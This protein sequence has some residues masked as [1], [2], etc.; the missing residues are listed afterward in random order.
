ML[1]RFEP[2][3]TSGIANSFLTKAVAEHGPLDQFLRHEDEN[4]DNFMHLVECRFAP[5]F[6]KPF[7]KDQDLERLKNVARDLL[8][9]KNNN[10]KTPVIKLL[11][12]P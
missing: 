3:T 8:G 4:G 6:W 12:H 2:K 10:G 5:P 1:L 7:V 11:E 9:L